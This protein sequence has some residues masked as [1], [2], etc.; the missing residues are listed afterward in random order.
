MT[1]GDGVGYQ[2]GPNTHKY[3]T[4]N[5]ITSWTVIP[6]HDPVTAIKHWYHVPTVVV[7]EIER[8]ALERTT[9]MAA[10]PLAVTDDD[11]DPRVQG[12]PGMGVLSNN[13]RRLPDDPEPT[14]RRGC[15]VLPY[16]VVALVIILSG[17]AAPRDDAAPRSAA[18]IPST[19]TSGVLMTAS[20]TPSGTGQRQTGASDRWAPPF[21]AADAPTPTGELSA[22][23]N[24]S[25][26]W[27]APT[28]TQCQS[29]GGNSKLGAVF[30]FRWGDEPYLV[31]VWHG[32]DYVDVTVVSFCQC[33]G[34]HNAI[35]LSPSAFEE[36]APLSRGRIDVLVEVSVGPA[37]TLPPTDR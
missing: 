22:I 4:A 18:V 1:H 2:D 25:A 35:D 26:T 20:A 7:E 37:V 34:T 27:C 31:R 8:S 11:W 15:S 10:D 19:G 12:E 28:K 14:R 30:G 3:R 23:Y 33:R 32:Q 6:L 29:W 36:L 17:L 21:P 13:Q 24:A 16:L 5:H 9:H